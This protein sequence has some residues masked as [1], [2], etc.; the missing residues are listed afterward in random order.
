[1]ALT[2]PEGAFLTLYNVYSGQLAVQVIGARVS[3]SVT[4]NQALATTLGSAIKSAWTTNF[5]ALCTSNTSLVRVAI[6]DMRTAN[7]PEFR[8]L[9][10]A[11]SGTATGTDPLPTQ[12]AAVVTLRTALSGKSFR[13]RTYFGGFSEAQSDAAGRASAAVGTAITAFMTAV[14]SALTASQLDLAVLSR[15]AE[16]FTITKTTFHND[17][18][19]TADIIGRGNARPGAA[20]PVTIIE[21]RNTNWETQ[22]SRANQRGAA[23][24]S[25]DAAIR[26]ELP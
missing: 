21:S 26:V 7:Q 24:T 17:G 10:A 23:P 20:T 11:V 14:D 16:A 9:A 12:L 8:D 19:T 3:G 15:P 22:R 1:M 4:F 5:A 6:R 25:L 18:T 2:I 13:G